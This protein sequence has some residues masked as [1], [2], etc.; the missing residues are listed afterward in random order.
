LNI[1]G[2]AGF[3][4]GE[5]SKFY[6]ETRYHYAWRLVGSFLSWTVWTKTDDRLL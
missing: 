1:G 2:G 6:I 3:R 4:I 5:S